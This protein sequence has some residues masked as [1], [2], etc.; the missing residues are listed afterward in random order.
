MRGRSSKRRAP[1]R[2]DLPSTACSRAR[3]K[4]PAF[5]RML[6]SKAAGTS[7]WYHLFRTFRAAPVVERRVRDGHRAAHL[8]DRRPELGLFQ[9]KGDLL[10]GVLALLHGTASFLGVKTVPDFPLQIVLG[11]GSLGHCDM[12]VV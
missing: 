3:S 7:A 12:R 9:R 10:V 6:Y 2:T 11:W 4:R 8:V 1:W 5:S